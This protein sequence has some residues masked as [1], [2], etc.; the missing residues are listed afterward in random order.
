MIP[1]TST[2][3][4]IARAVADGSLS[5]AAA[6]RLL[7]DAGFADPAGILRDL[8]G[9]AGMTAL[10]PAQQE[11]QRF[12]RSRAGQ[13]RFGMQNYIETLGVIAQARAESDHLTL[14]YDSWQ[15]YVDGEFGDG[16]IQLPPD[17]RRKAVEELRL[18]GATQREIG[19]TLGV[20][21][22]TV[23]RE[24]AAGVSDETPGGAGPVAR[25]ARSPL[26]EAM[27]GAIEDAG[28]R[29]EDHRADGPGGSHPPAAAPDHPASE[30]PCAPGDPVGV[31]APTGGAGSVPAPAAGG[32]APPAA[33][34]PPCEKCGEPIAAGQ[35]RE[36]YTRCDECDP[37][38]D[39]VDHGDG[40][41]G[42]RV[43]AE[44]DPAYV[45]SFGEN[46]HGLH[47]EC[48]E[49]D[50]VVAHLKPGGG[51]PEVLAAAREHY[52]ICGGAT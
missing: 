45:L 16:R 34:S 35:A 17:L 28:R 42:C 7:S 26:V 43:V 1:D 3:G 41:H 50:G 2:V 20:S 47:L 49:C 5:R 52:Q 23:N 51:L 36:G 21:A 22:A 38:G 8:L 30:P 31:A 15:A 14:G 25:P 13:I 6:E 18:A 39:H 29:A 46:E 19:H 24:L 11:R 40:C 9:G 44:T 10:T 33:P 37:D 32:T 27:T 48:G 12:A 4:A